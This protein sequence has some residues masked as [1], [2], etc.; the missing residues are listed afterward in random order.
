MTRIAPGTAIDGF[1]VQERMHAGGNGY[2]YRVRRAGDETP[3]VMKVPGIGHGEPTL[4]VVS[5]DSEQAI[6]PALSGPHVPRVLA[7][8]GDPAHPYLVMEEIG[9]EGLAGIVARA[10]L[11]PEEVARIGAGIADALHAIHRQDV[12]H[13]D[14]RPENCIVRANGD[15]VLLDFGYAHHARFPDLLA[16]EQHFAAG[17]AA[18]VSPEQLRGV[19]GD[20]RSDVF[21]LGVLLYQLA[22]GELPFGD[23]AT[24][25]GMR[26]RLWRAPPPPRKYVP[27]LPPWLQEVILRCLELDPDQRAPSAAHVAFDLRHPDGVALTPRS[28]A[29]Q[30]ARATRQL[31]SWWRARRARPASPPRP[32]LVAHAPVILIAVDTEHP[33]D[34]RHPALQQAARAIMAMHADYRLLLVSAIHAARLGD[35]ERVEESASGRQ[36]AHRNRLREWVAPL[37][38]P[39]SRVS[40]HVVESPDAAATILGMARANNVDLIVLGAPL[41]GERALAWWHSVASAVA[42]D[43]PC[44]VHLVRAAGD[45]PG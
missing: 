13:H 38:L 45:S 3:L 37:K 39:P 23:P 5:F 30:G 26:D 36:L 12:V 6:L 7:L 44:S 18:Y 31:A 43:A 11:A 24:F 29:T 16:E 1:V 14:V 2:I 41:P 40:L 10:P 15:V 32:G 9:G 4:G 22:T 35:G 20:P 33:E 25:A 42:A 19:R 8:G 34:D 21:A 27:A 28:T 17:S